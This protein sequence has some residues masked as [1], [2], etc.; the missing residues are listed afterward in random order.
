MADGEGRGVLD[1]MVPVRF[2]ADQRDRLRRVAAVRGTSVSALLRE[3]VERLLGE[4]G[5]S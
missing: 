1:V 4:A 5:G 2:A 3:A